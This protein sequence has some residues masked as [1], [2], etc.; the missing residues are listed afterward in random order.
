[1]SNGNPVTWEIT[2]V[3]Q[4]TQYSPSATPIPGKRVS[5]T[6]SI[7]YDGTVFVPNSVFGD[8]NAL[9]RIID[10]EVTMVAAAHGITGTVNG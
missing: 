1:M 7:G 6:T 8:V 5:F 9:R 10:G 3:A 2:A 4:D